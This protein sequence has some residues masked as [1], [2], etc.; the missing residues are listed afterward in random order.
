MLVKLLIELLKNIPYKRLQ[1]INQGITSNVQG[2]KN[3]HAE[4]KQL[5]Y[6][7]KEKHS[8]Y[9]MEWIYIPDTKV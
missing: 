6:W 5:L 1:P 9:S 7:G 2:A 8:H 3:S 4:Y